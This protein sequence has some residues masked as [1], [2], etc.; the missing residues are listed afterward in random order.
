MP[1]FI[2]ESPSKEDSPTL[3]H[4]ETSGSMLSL[5][6]ILS[7]EGWCDGKRKNSAASKSPS[8]VTDGPLPGEAAKFPDSSHSLQTLLSSISGAKRVPNPSAGESCPINIEQR[9]PRRCPVPQ[10]R[11]DAGTL[12]ESEPAPEQ[13]LLKSLRR[14]TEYS[15]RA[16]LLILKLEKLGAGR[17][18]RDKPD[19]D[20]LRKVDVVVRDCA[21][22]IAK[23][24]ESDN[25]LPDRLD[26]LERMLVASH[27]Y[28][29]ELELTRQINDSLKKMGSQF[30]IYLD[31]GSAKQREIPHTRLF[32]SETR[33]IKLVNIKEFE[34]TPLCDYRVY[35][36]YTKNPEE[37]MLRGYDK[38]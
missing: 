6:D 2:H 35:K 10:R 29:A 24:I 33:S 16:E 18:Y 37:Q 23:I 26:T 31:T 14:E 32:Q 5:S 1:F 7:S 20:L 25:L 22:E 13:L 27:D 4:G 38:K 17:R 36:F 28:N 19:P 8:A 30:R 21:R 34:V 15:D 12:A 9:E 3:D 11:R